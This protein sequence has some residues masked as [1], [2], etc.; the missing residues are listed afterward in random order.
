MNVCVLHIF[1]TRGGRMKALDHLELELQMVVSCHM[2]A[3]K[4]T[5]SLEDQ[6]GLIAELSLHPF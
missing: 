1:G 2:A 4:R 5:G 3:G 6:P